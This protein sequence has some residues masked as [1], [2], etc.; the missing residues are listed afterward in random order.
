MVDTYNIWEMY[1]FKS[2]PFNP[3]PLLVNGGELPI[4]QSFFGRDKELEQLLKAIK[5]NKTSRNLIYGEIG[6]G[7]TTFA[8]YVRY[9][10]MNDGYFTTLGEIAIQYN[11][12]PDDFMFNTIDAIYTSI[13]RVK[14]LRKKFDSELIK[15][16]DIIFGMQ[17]GET[18]GGG[19]SIIGSGLNAQK[20]NLYG[21]PRLNANSLKLLMQD[22]LDDFNKAGFKGIIIHYNNLE[23][24]QDKNEGNLQK[25]LNGVRDFLQ[26]RGAHFLFVGE[27]KV[28]ELFQQIKRFEDIF[29]VPILLTPFEIS[30]IKQ[31]IE[32]RMR[33]LSVD[34]LKPIS[35]FDFESLEILFDLYSGNLRGILRSLDCAITQVVKSRPVRIDSDILK[36]SLY[37]FAVS[38]FMENLAENDLKVLTAILDKKEVTNK[39]LSEHLKIL[40]QNISASL[41]KL[42]QAGAIRLSR[43]EGRSRYYVPSQEALWILLTPSV[44][45]DGQTKLKK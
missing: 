44:D 13:S 42:R 38:R 3:D 9:K 1:G 45:I 12:T 43:S 31:I 8:N 26:V 2:N 22:I 36:Q 34:G 6:I 5:S 15:K 19:V 18:T 4:E 32:K 10:L 25:I 37:S 29:Q 30:D 7:K 16:L 40:P 33:I 17:R 23:L 11:W 41:T 24:M 35:P 20:G 27:K 39:V 28:F 14:D 21:A